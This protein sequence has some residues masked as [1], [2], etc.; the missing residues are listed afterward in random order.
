MRLSLTNFGI[1]KS[2][3]FEFPDTGLTLISGQ[4]GKGKTTILRAIN[5]ALTGE[6]TKLPTIGEKKCIVEFDYKGMFITRCNSLCRLTLII[7]DELYEESEAQSII[8]NQI[9]KNFGISGYIQQKGENSFLNMSPSDKLKFLEQIVFHDIPIEE[10]KEKAKKIYAEAERNLFNIQGE[11]KYLNDN[12]VESPETFNYTLED[13]ENTL[14]F[15]TSHI[16]STQITKFQK[17]KQYQEFYQIKEQVNL[18]KQRIDDLKLQ[19]VP[20]EIPDRN[21]EEYLQQ[22]MKFK[23]YQSEKKRI[24]SIQKI[25]EEKTKELVNINKEIDSIKLPSQNEKLILEQD[26]RDFTKN[27]ED[28]LQQK[29]LKKLLREFSKERYTF[30]TSE[31]PKLEEKLRELIQNRDVKIC[32]NCKI[33]LRIVDNTLLHDFKSSDIIEYSIEKENEL[34]QSLSSLKKELTSL[35]V[36]KSKINEFPPITRE[37]NLDVKEFE[38]A[39]Q[40]IK[41]LQ[42]EH[43]SLE[44]KYNELCRYKLRLEQQS[45][46]TQIE[47]LEVVNE[48]TISE[49]ELNER[50]VNRKIRKAQIEKIK[51]DNY[52]T[53]KTL[54][55]YKNKLESIV[56]PEE[57][58]K[59]IIESLG[60]EIETSQKEQ[61][62]FLQLQNECKVNIEKHERFKSYSNSKNRISNTLKEAE[63]KLTLSKK[64]NEKILTAEMLSLTNM[65]EEI[66]SHLAGYLEVFFPDNP[67]TIDLCMF[68]ESSKIIKNQ[69]HIKVGYR[70]VSTDLTTLSG[71]EKDRV[72]L[73]FTL[74]LAEIFSIPL[75]MLDET[76]S[77]LDRETTENIL[78]HIQKD[79]KSILVVAHQVSTG[80]FDHV[81]TI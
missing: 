22:W 60:V 20:E 52:N 3:T 64:F 9:G 6:G 10:I 15:L 55:E 23:K 58:P 45:N 50:I 32:P 54:D 1:W 72:N 40:D 77:S 71:G 30:L 48:P 5:Y 17:E 63:V 18:L 74:A 47:I 36:L 76:L 66:N 69:I 56:C 79:S 4:S 37:I 25:L 26:L 11:L 28:F 8:Y 81:Y 41:K 12:P 67:I 46:D 44:Q 33:G 43:I 42:K 24:E 13:I 65:I 62:K 51:L 70:G 31:I 68:K 78:E 29:A 59:S 38:D 14:S 57:V 61:L 27:L 16:K 73:A 80:L 21:E 34:K 75:L 39:I 49:Q 19:E 2:K 7:D 53:Q 35:E